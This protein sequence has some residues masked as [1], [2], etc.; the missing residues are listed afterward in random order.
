MDFHLRRR[1]WSRESAPSVGRRF[2]K[3]SLL[4]CERDRD[5]DRDKETERVCEK[6][7]RSNS[8][9]KMDTEID[10]ELIN[11]VVINLYQN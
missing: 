2:M 3:P 10:K 9:L 4:V 11:T 7:Y 1:A 6:K 8:K 5:K